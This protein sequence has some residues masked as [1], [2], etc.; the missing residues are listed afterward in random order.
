LAEYRLNVGPGYRI[1]LTRRGDR[2]IVL[3]GGGTKHRQDNDIARARANLTDYESRLG[4][5]F[6]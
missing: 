3:L 5:R 1:Y 4:E 6:H 2:F